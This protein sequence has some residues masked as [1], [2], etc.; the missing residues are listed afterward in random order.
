MDSQFDKRIRI[1]V[2]SVIS[3]AIISI[4]AIIDNSSFSK[5]NS[6]E[7]NFNGAFE[8][9][10]EG[11]YDKA[12]QKFIW[13]QNNTSYENSKL[14]SYGYS[15]CNA[16]K[17][18]YSA[19]YRN[20]YKQITNAQKFMYLLNTSNQEYANKMINLI[21]SK[22]NDYKSQYD[23]ED[24]QIKMQTSSSNSSYNSTSYSKVDTSENETCK[25]HGCNRKKISNSNYCSYH[26][27]S[28]KGCYNEVPS[29]NDRCTKHHKEYMDENGLGDKP[30]V[31]N[32]AVA[33][34]NKDAYGSSKYCISHKCRQSGCNNG[35]WNGNGYCYDHCPH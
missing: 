32:C 18:Y 27:C 13:L 21:E 7:V 14:A 9:A 35:T 31:E 15:F 34:C 28:V 25:H 3:V 4:I 29:G 26:T 6:F 11:D 20:A 22:Y 23:Q 19:D 12:K 10:V 1:A 16:L 5:Q 17:D 30:N 33:G 2:I 8:F 24:Q